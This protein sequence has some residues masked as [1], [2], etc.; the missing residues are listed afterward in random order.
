LGRPGVFFD[1]ICEDQPG[2]RWQALFQQR[3]P[4]YQRWFLRDGNRARPSYLAGRR[5]LREHMPELVPL[6]E[7][8]CDLA[9]GGD[10]EARFLAQWCPPSYITGCAQA[11]WLDPAG[12]SE[13]ILLR[14]YDY[15]PLLLE[16]SWLATRWLGQRVVAM[17]DCLWGALDGI[18]ESG[19]AVSL[20]FGGRTAVGEGFGIP[21]VLRYLLEVAG[22][23]AD[24]V[25]IL[26]RL[27][28]H[29]A[30]NVSLLDRSGAWAT[31]FLAPDRATEVVL[32]PAVANHQHAVEWLAHARATQSEE[33]EQALYYAVKKAGRSEEVVRAMLKPPLFQTSYGRG[34][35]T[36]YTA[37][38]RPLSLGAE[39]VWPDACWPQSCLQFSEGS[40]SVSFDTNQGEPAWPYA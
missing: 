28:V 27:P 7:R 9:G 14:N 1:A 15:S 31:V 21:L 18:N 39:L 24:A 11:V 13:P 22:S 38:Y 32:R 29:M 16:G 25:V 23:T 26:Q 6:Y 5:A 3:W 37:V 33:R 8:L 36:L 2:P 30:Y 19:L 20:S 35:G 12:L 4:A 40:L 17:S 10:V 34:Y